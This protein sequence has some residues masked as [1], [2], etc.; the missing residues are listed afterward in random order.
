MGSE[1]CIR[2]R[3]S[4]LG[5]QTRAQLTPELAERMREFVARDQ[6]NKPT[7]FR[8]QVRKQF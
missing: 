7:D 6:L 3:D 8:T 4:V 1:M 5:S 2:D